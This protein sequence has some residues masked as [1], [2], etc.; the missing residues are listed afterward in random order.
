MYSGAYFDR[1]K[2][3]DDTNQQRE[4]DRRMAMLGRLGLDRGARVLDAGCATGDFLAAASARYTM[5]GLDV[6]ADAVD[7]ARERN[8][9]FADRIRAGFVEDQA[10]GVGSYDA[11][12][13]WDVVEHIWDPVAACQRLVGALRPGGY[14]LLSTPDIGAP[15][16]RAMRSRW[17]F[18]TP[19]EHLGLFS[20]PSLTWLLERRLGLTIV[21]TF[22]A[23]KWVNVG[24]LTYKLGRMFPG[25]VPPWLAT[26]LRDTRLGRA[27]LYV[28]TNDIRYV[29]ARVPD[30]NEG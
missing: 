12:V 30:G 6:S 4:N 16:A 21:E 9:A 3:D 7:I 27:S 13:L 19:P 25:L 23:G 11:I 5:S 1:G 26:R 8:P 28:P 20:L 18:M 10:F 15:V 17:A 29:T 2:Y 14:L 24:F 22:A